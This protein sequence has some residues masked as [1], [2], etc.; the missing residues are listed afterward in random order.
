MDA[1][2]LLCEK[3]E[4]R[5]DLDWSRRAQTV[6]I[7]A[8]VEEGFSVALEK[9][10]PEDFASDPYTVYLGDSGFHMHLAS[11]EEAL[12]CVAWCFSG[13]ARLVE[14]VRGAVIS[15]RLEML[16]DGA[17]EPIEDWARIGLFWRRKATRQLRNPNLLRF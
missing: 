1:I 16:Q 3:L 12:E 9:S 15:A 8:P 2:A 10:C 4:E 17:W 5:G 7:A 6:L 14:T 11:A 13:E